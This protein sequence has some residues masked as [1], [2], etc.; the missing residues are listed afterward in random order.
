M[1]DW[2]KTLERAGSIYDFPG[3]RADGSPLVLAVLDGGRTSEPPN[4][5]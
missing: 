3:R 2:T 5:G 1:A 4:A